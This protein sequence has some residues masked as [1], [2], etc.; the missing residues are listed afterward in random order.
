M[1]RSDINCRPKAVCELILPI[2]QIG[3]LG[4]SE[5][6]M[7]FI[8]GAKRHKLSAEGRLRI[9]T[10]DTT[11]RSIRSIGRINGNHLLTVLLLY[12]KL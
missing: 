12:A 3:V 5:G 1:E 10:P 11:N 4:V 2:Q 6:L 9:N 8:Y 7:V